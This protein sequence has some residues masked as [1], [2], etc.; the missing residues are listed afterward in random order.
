MNSNLWIL[1]CIF[2]NWAPQI[3]KSGPLRLSWTPWRCE[4]A[5]LAAVPPRHQPKRLHLSKTSSVTNF[6][7]WGYIYFMYVEYITSCFHIIMCA[8]DIF[9]HFLFNMM[10]CLI[11]TQLLSCGWKAWRPRFMDMPVQAYS[12]H[13]LEAATDL[14]DTAMFQSSLCW[15]KRS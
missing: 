7:A 10:R 4:A 9:K 13:S 15:W 12:L 2:G 11:N 14:S 3:L 8:S 6:Q 1:Y 5:E